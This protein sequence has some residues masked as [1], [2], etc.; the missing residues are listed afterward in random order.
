MKNIILN[1]CRNNII[2]SLAILFVLISCTDGKQKN[3][4]KAPTPLTSNNITKKEVISEKDF[5]GQWYSSKNQVYL[6]LLPKTKNSTW[7]GILKFETNGRVFDW[8]IDWEILGDNINIS[9][10]KNTELENFWYFYP[11]YEGRI[12]NGSLINMY[13]IFP[14]KV[15]ENKINF[16]EILLMT[17]SPELETLKV[18]WKLEEI[19]EN[20]KL[21]YDN[22][23]YYRKNPFEH[24]NI[25]IKRN[26]NLDLSLDFLNQKPKKE[27]KDN[28]Q[29]SLI[30]PIIRKGIW[31]ARS[32][33]EYCGNQ[34]SEI[35]MF[36]D[37]YLEFDGKFWHLKDALA[38]AV[39]TNTTTKMFFIPKKFLR[40]GKTKDNFTYYIY[41]GKMHHDY[42]ID[43]KTTSL[44]RFNQQSVDASMQIFT[45]END[46]PTKGVTF[47]L[48]LKK[49]CKYN[50]GIID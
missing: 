49:T 50:I 11:K 36:Q 23:S 15:L 34:K 35:L 10:N 47:I 4:L 29:K 40:S 8:K 46:R 44:I 18:S 12:S 33:F 48:K 7:N 32:V 41:E 9:L 26:P 19:T 27:L 25:L 13:E 1:K 14:D 37:G 42:A 20:E 45:D 17:L 2:H 21:E 39:G 22:L 16:D 3:K 31:K 6:D 38:R 5:V 43:N 30:S 24:N 28:T